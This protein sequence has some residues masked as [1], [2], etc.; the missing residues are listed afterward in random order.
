MEAHRSKTRP[1]R[2]KKP[3]GNL[4]G[5]PKKTDCQWQDVAF[6]QLLAD[7]RGQPEA[8]KWIKANRD[9]LTADMADKTDAVLNRS[10][11]FGY[12]DGG[13]DKDPRL[14]DQQHGRG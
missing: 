6:K 1:P 10:V 12:K 13:E 3:T 7:Y 11:P 14:V 5:R 2:P 8:L 9:N 4:P